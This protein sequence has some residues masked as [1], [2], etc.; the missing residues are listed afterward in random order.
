SCLTGRPPFEGSPPL[1]VLAK[2]IF[3]EAPRVTDLRP[4]VPVAVEALVARLLSKN[5]AD[6]PRHGAAPGVELGQRHAAR[7]APPGGPR[8]PPGLTEGEQRLVSVIVADVEATVSCDPGG[9][10]LTPEELDA[11]F[12]RLCEVAA[13]FSARLSKLRDGPMMATLVD[14]P[15]SAADQAA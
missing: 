13:S 5:P 9:T 11:P 8:P 12:V 3:D 7:R 1:A 2:I 10:T 15:G 4:D 6:R 14:N